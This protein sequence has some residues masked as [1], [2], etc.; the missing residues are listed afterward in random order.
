MP[1]KRLVTSVLIIWLSTSCT[2]TEIIQ[3]PTFAEGQKPKNIILMIGDGMGLSQIS[4]AIY[5]SKETLVFEEFKTIGLQKT[6]SATNIITDSGASATAMACGVK[7]YNFAIG[8]DKDS[9][10]VKSILAEAEENNMATGVVVTSSIVHA[11][12]A[13]F[14][15]HQSFRNQYEDIA[16]DFLDVDIDFMVGGGK[17]YFDRRK[18]DDRNL[19]KELVRKGYVVSDYFNNT[20]KQMNPD[21]RW[22]FAFFT[23][24]QQ[25]IQANAGRSYLPYA[26]KK[27]V[28]FL[29]NRSE[30]GFFLLIEGS[31]IDWAGH[32]ND[33]NYLLSEMEDFNKTLRAMMDFA[34]KDGNTLLIV[35]ADH[36]TGGLALNQKGNPMKFK[37]AYTTNNHTAT[38][39]PVFAFGPSAELFGGIY[40]NTQL[41]AKM[42]QALGFTTLNGTTGISEESI[43]K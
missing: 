32:S 4:A 29:P 1:L 19:Y 27:A 16:K 9:V 35:T 28:N 26:C 30:E 8:L 10:A 6:H 43:D 37:H 33:F 22:N 3:M 11:T 2:P 13:A 12:P 5:S 15:A 20:I 31:Q 40:E 14:V 34:I 21:P 7:T 36:E 18:M 17:K 42:R 38:M 39:V 23:A 24:D 25:P 41:H